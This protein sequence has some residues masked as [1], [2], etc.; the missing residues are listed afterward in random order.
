[1]LLCYNESMNNVEEKQTILA[2]AEA[3]RNASV[4]GAL[5]SNYARPLYNS[6]IKYYSVTSDPDQHWEDAIFSKEDFEAR[7]EKFLEETRG[8]FKN[9]RTVD[10]YYGRA[11]RAVEVYLELKK[12]GR[13]STKNRRTPMEKNT[14]LK[15]PLAKSIRK[16][17][18]ARLREA[19]T[20]ND[21]EEEFEILSLP[22]RS[23]KYAFIV[24]PK[25]T[26]IEDIK[27]IHETLKTAVG[28]VGI[29]D[30]ENAE[31]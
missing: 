19:I 12:N 1:M 4:H 8:E 10:G 13:V 27:T 29:G 2:I 30:A 26:A 22:S 11:R 25:D 15:E 21:A 9:N 18:F 3:L 16:I 6:L 14:Q 5:R 23:G 7:R 17:W 31:Q 28:D 24:V 20:D